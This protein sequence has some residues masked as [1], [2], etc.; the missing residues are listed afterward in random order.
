MVASTVGIAGDDY[1]VADDEGSG[2]VGEP[3]RQRI[4][5]F[6]PGAST[7]AKAFCRCARGRVKRIEVFTT[8]GDDCSRVPSVWTALQ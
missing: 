7:Y 3:A 5:E 1:N 8:N 2:A 4:V 6:R